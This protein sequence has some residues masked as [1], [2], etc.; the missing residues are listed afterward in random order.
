[1]ANRELVP[2]NNQQ[3]NVPALL[4]QGRTSLRALARAY[5]L[6]E[7]AGQA[8]A[9]I[10]AKRSLELRLVTEVVPHAELERRPTGPCRS[11]DSRVL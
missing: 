2:A 1:M 9:T 11:V 10:D 6:T 8:P 7:V 3:H 5:F 4:V